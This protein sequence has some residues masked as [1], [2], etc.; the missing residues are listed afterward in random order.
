MLPKYLLCSSQGFF[1]RMRIP[2]HLQPV[3]K[4]K[5]LKKAI[6]TTSRIV[7]ERQAIIYAAKAF[8]EFDRLGGV[9]SDFRSFKNLT[10][11]SG[12]QTFTFDENPK[13]QL[14]ELKALIDAG[15]IKAGDAPIP[16]EYSQPTQPLIT[17]MIE[18]YI[19]FRHLNSDKVKELRSKFGL[20]LEI[21]G[22]DKEIDRVT[23]EDAV[24][25]RDTYRLLPRIR[26]S[27]KYRDKSIA[28][29]ISVP[30]DKVSTNSVSQRLDTLRSFF[31]WLVD[32]GKLR[33]NPFK[34]VQLKDDSKSLNKRKP[35]T[36]DDLARI[37]NYKIWTGRSFNHAWEYWLPLLL[38]YTGARVGEICQL[39]RKDITEIDGVWCISVNDTPTKDEP[40][41]V[42]GDFAKRVKT[43]SS[44]RDIP[45]HS[46]LLKLGFLDFVK[47]FTGRIFPD[48]KPTNGR[49][50]KYPCR[51][52]N[53]FF[54]PEIGVKETS[55]KTF[56]SFR[57]T[58]LN[59]LKQL[60]VS[61]EERAQLAGHSTASITENTYGAEFNIQ[62]MRNLVE[63]LNFNSELKNILSWGRPRART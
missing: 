12:S 14:Q 37:F 31:Q 10:L 5:E 38:L 44:V 8:E 6:H 16:I 7:A 22:G 55:V 57:H 23:I 36:Q 42:W 25:Y 50:S 24:N 46:Q 41:D 27:A 15:I 54:L 3:F 2:Q 18:S 43:R 13:L 19:T 56:Y 51:R 45:I 62:I 17:E 30:G 11:T 29:L 59:A 61:S 9:V 1:F 60:R 47:G 48:I 33:L 63:Q 26:T 40:E 28:E 39:E 20:F 35:F 49:I 58:T 52:F 21:I 32:T 53:E 4:K 34:T